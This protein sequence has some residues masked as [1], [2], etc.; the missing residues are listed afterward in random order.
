MYPKFIEL[1][2]KDSGNQFIANVDN[3]VTVGET[4]T[5]LAL[6]SDVMKLET[7]EGYKEIKTLITDSGCLIKKADPRLDTEH[8]L[9]MDDL[10]T[11]VGEP[12]WN[13]NNGRWMLVN[14]ID[15]VAGTDFAILTESSGIGYDFD[16]AML[17]AKPLYR[18]KKN[19]AGSKRKD[20]DDDTTGR[21]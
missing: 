4:G 12:V 14:R 15:D 1:H 7:V 11:M 20:E 21:Y 5:I 2:D 3:I 17:K 8:P 6:P 10:M 18:M 19:I 9:T 13:S 16:E